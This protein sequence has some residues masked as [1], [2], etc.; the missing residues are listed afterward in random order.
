MN[1]TPIGK[2]HNKKN[3]FINCSKVASVPK[4]NETLLFEKWHPTR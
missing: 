4:A 2:N 3:V 1:Q